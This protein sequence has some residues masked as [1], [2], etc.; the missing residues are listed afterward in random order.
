MLGVFWGAAAASGAFLVAWPK[1]PSRS[2]VAAGAGGC[3]PEI[4]AVLADVRRANAV[5]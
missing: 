2:H 3:S 1:F 4:M 5:C